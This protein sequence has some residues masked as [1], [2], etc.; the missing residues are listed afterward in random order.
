MD[1][2]Q[3]ERTMNDMASR[4]IPFFFMV[5]A[6]AQHW[7]VSVISEALASGYQWNIGGCGCSC[8]SMPIERQFF[9]Q[10]EPIDFSCYTQ[11]F[12]V[13]REGQIRGETWLANLTF[14]S[15]LNTNLSL[16]EIFGAANAEF[17]LHIPGLLTVF[18]PERF[19]RI[20]PE[21]CIS[22]YPMKG[23]INADNPNASV[24][25]LQDTKEVAEHI[26]IVDL[27]R[28]DIGMVA[29]RVEV[30]RFRFISKIETRETTLLQVSSEITGELGLDWKSRVGTVFA[31]LLPA[32]SVTGAP[33]NRTCEIIREAEQHERGWYA[34]VFGCFNGKELDSAVSIR[35][36]RQD[37][38][39]NLFYHSGGGITINSDLHREYAE[40]KEKIYVPFS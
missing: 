11:G 29:E 6:W 19:V 36:I 17:R 9:F 18:S 12:Q 26:T 35:F 33:K 37:G 8:T 1:A 31:A 16:E 27:I 21:G 28:N 15:K 32:G 22:S 10:S 23:T 14:P 25:I 24:E 7:V 38:N 5:D 20:S 4:G 34:G 30:P 39:G 2:K 13:V 3:G 40:L